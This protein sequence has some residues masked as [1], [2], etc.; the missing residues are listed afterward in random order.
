MQRMPTESSIR[1][2]GGVA[3]DADIPISNIR[4]YQEPSNA[5]AISISGRG[6]IFLQDWGKYGPLSF[7]LLVVLPFLAIESANSPTAARVQEGG[8]G[9]DRWVSALDDPALARPGDEPGDEPALHRAFGPFSFFGLFRD[10]CAQAAASEREP[11]SFDPVKGFLPSLDP[12]R[13]VCAC[14]P[15]F[16]PPLFSARNC[17]VRRSDVSQSIERAEF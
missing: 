8:A 13:T 10:R 16:L 9:R 5:A 14:S 3:T 17:P 1:T 7:D 2:Y 4:R 12:A 15:L 6:R 11:L